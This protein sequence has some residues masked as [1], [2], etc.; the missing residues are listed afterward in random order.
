MSSYVNRPT[1]RSIASSYLSFQWLGF[2]HFSLDSLECVRV[3]AVTDSL[4]RLGTETWLATNCNLVWSHSRHAVDTAKGI[5][6]SS[7]PANASCVERVGFRSVS[8]HLCLFPFFLATDVSSSVRAHTIFRGHPVRIR[9]SQ[10]IA[11]SRPVAVV[12]RP[13]RSMFSATCTCVNRY[14]PSALQRQESFGC[15]STNSPIN[16]STNSVFQV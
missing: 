6:S 15:Y 3:L 14:L 7:R 16:R 4:A 12:R 9:G 10:R 2:I 5:C 8:D 11:R 1:G 13:V